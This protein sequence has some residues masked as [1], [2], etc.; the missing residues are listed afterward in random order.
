LDYLKE[1]TSE[2]IIKSIKIHKER[3]IIEGVISYLIAKCKE[4]TKIY[5]ISGRDK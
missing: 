1:G 4:K 5:L 3:S 2:D